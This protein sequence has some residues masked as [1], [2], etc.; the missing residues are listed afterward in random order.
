M[1]L[2][3]WVQK[4]HL[5]KKNIKKLCLL[6]WKNDAIKE[7]INCKNNDDMTPMDIA[8][9]RN[10]L[11]FIHLLIQNGADLYTQDKDGNTPLH[12]AIKKN[13]LRLIES[14]MQDGGFKFESEIKK[15]IH[16]RNCFKNN[17]RSTQALLI[18]SQPFRG[19]DF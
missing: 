6:Y 1:R 11:E 17:M 2:K 16:R 19:N 13:Y 8:I 5:K 9:Q 12:L 14:I 18:L 10:K 4:I 3:N 15:E 7:Q